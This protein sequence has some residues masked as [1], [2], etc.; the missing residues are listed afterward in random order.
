MQ[1][2]LV[3]RAG[4]ETRVPLTDAQ[5][6]AFDTIRRD[7]RRS[8][9]TERLLQGDVG[10]GAAE[11]ALAAAMVVVGG[12]D[13][14]FFVYSDALDAEH[15]YQFQL[16]RWRALDVEPVLL[17]GKPTKV[18]AEAIQRGDSHVVYG[19]RAL[20]AEPPPTR[21]LGLVVVEQAQ[22]TAS[23]R[24]TPST[25]P[26]PGRTSWSARPRPCPRCS[27]SPRTARCR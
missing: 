18:Q 27:R 19:T 26:A 10:A 7:L 8:Q 2:A 21:R 22:G 11:V 4:A 13:Q 12:K 17:V 15:H 9:P 14:V 16:E 20:L 5:E 23:R 25:P 1:H 24:W 6:A 3:A